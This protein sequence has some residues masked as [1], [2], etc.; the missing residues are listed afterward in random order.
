MNQISSRSVQDFTHFLKSCISQRDLLTGKSLHTIYIKNLIPHSTYLSNHFI[1]LYSKCRRLSA[2]RHAFDA[3][4]HPNVFSFNTIVSAYAKESQPHIAHQLFDEIPQ[5]D[6]VS[7]N[8]LISAYADRGDTQPAL[9]LFT[10]MRESGFDMDGFTFSAAVTATC[11][12]VRLIRQ[13][14][15][16]AVSGGFNAYTSVN[17]S[18]I[19]YYSKNGLLDE[20]KCVFDHMGREKDEVTW[21]SMIVAYSQHR[22]GIK[23]LAL[24]REMI[25]MEL[26]VDIFTLAS[27]LTAFTYLEDLRGGLQFHCQL[28]KKGFNQNT[29]VGSGLI[30]LYSKCHGNMS[31]CKKVFSEIV[32]PDLVLWNT[33]VSGYSQNDDLAEDALFC[34]KQMQREGYRPDDCTFVCVIS[35]SSNLSSPSQGK[36]IHCLALKS[37][38]PSNRISVSNALIT[39]YSKCGNLVDARRVF[40]KMPEHN[41]VTF[42]SLITG[43]AQHGFPMEALHLFD[44]MIETSINPTSIT[45][46]SILS[47]CA[48]TGKVKEGR[49]YFSL[50]SDRFGIE[51]EEEHFSCMIDLLGRA[52]QLEEAERLIESMPFNPGIVGWGA[53]L[54]SCRTYSN[55]ELAVKA[56]K[57]CLLLEPSNAAPYVILAH[58]YAK[59]NKWEEVAT[60]RKCLRNNGVKKN[61]GCSWIEINKKIH[62]FVADD[63]SHPMLNSITNY[64]RHLLNKMK[65]VGYEPDVVRDDGTRKDDKG[66]HSEKLAVVFGLLSTKDGEPLYV[67]KNLRI[68]GDCH[69]AIKIISGLTRREITVR[70]ARRFHCFKDGRC[71]CGD[72]W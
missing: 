3:V 44:H 1:L 23:S 53:L 35:A 25:H 63:S 27:V 32:E 61:P 45:F 71:S 22:E 54:G 52:G 21:N 65:E 18:L 47:A 13:L 56:A 7:Y 8:T 55:L 64:W 59:A 40:D 29:H 67:V 48:H 33:M 34:F 51:P 60:I 24:Y 36:Q 49:K 9:H 70:D 28:I 20:A 15:K 58:M 12:D 50:M 57:Q 17:N 41:T 42:N 16:L 30:D 26:T 2:A 69:N 6:L 11:K 68:C 14:H 62:V 37:D 5:P 38:I 72:Y 39:M 19:T 10:E 4:Q 46:I 66:R 43:Y 31:D